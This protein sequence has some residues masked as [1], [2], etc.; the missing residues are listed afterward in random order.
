MKSDIK[1]LLY[2]QEKALVLKHPLVLLCPCDSGMKFFLLR[3]LFRENIFTNT[4]LFPVGF[5][6]SSYF[7]ACTK[8]K[9]RIYNSHLIITFFSLLSKSGLLLII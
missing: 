8:S 7:D 1:V 6:T 3:L 9:D 4:A 2:D 5:T